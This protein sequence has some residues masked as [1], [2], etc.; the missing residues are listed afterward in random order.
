MVVAI[1]INCQKYH[2][3][4]RRPFSMRFLKYCPEDSHPILCCNGI[5][6]TLS[7][8]QL[9]LPFRCQ[10]TSQLAATLGP[11]SCGTWAK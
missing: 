5:A 9:H 10:G 2:A 1:G 8:F 4:F 3:V 6:A 7:A 11:F